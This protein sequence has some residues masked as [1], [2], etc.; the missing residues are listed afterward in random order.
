MKFRKRNFAWY[1]DFKYFSPANN[2]LQVR[3]AEDDHALWR[4][5]CAQ[6]RTL[7]KEI[8][9]LKMKKGD[10]GEISERRIQVVLL[11]WIYSHHTYFVLPQENLAPLM[12]LCF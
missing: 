9:D 12:Y 1:Q 10:S 5:T 2:C 4:E 3:G 8:F 6:L 7:M 11:I